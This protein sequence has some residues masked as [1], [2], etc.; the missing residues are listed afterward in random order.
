MDAEGTGGGG[1]RGG[2]GGG[3]RGVGPTGVGSDTGVPTQ[4]GGSYGQRG[5]GSV[6]VGARD[7]NAP[8]QRQ[9]RV[10]E[11]GGGGWDWEKSSKK[12]TVVLGPMKKIVLLHGWAKMRTLG[13]A[14]PEAA[15]RRDHATYGPY[16]LK[17]ILLPSCPFPQSQLRTGV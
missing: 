1:G 7:R 10:Q 9:E 11:K 16:D 15:R 14:G 12:G 17:F 4:Q 5:G 2:G 13:C 8:E 6:T 3:G